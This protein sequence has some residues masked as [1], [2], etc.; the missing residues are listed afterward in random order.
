MWFCKTRPGKWLITRKC[1]Y[2]IILLVVA[3]QSDT[4]FQ[5]EKFNM[6]GKEEGL[7]YVEIVFMIAL[8]LVI[9]STVVV[10]HLWYC[11]MWFIHGMGFVKTM[12]SDISVDYYKKD[13]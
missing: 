8:L 10:V 1:G 4:M 13:W 3:A 6:I 9:F 11:N 7:G 2:L 12:N 5:Y